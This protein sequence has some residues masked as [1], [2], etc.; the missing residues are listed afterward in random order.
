MADMRNDVDD[1]QPNTL[2]LLRN[3][4]LIVGPLWVATHAWAA[5]S[6]AAQVNDMTGTPNT[7]IAWASAAS[8]ILQA[9]F[10]TLVGIYLVFWVFWLELRRG[11]G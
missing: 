11:A 10:L 3:L 4:V 1:P 6:L 8:S 7:A 9:L 2:G 5:L